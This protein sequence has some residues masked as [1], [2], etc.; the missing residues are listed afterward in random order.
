MKTKIIITLTLLFIS[1]HISHAQHFASNLPD[2]IAKKTCGVGEWIM[3][4]YTGELN[5]D[6]QGYTAE[7]QY[8]PEA[9]ASWQASG[10]TITK[11]VDIM[12]PNRNVSCKYLATST[13]PTGYYRYKIT[14]TPTGAE[15]FSNE[16]L[17]YKETRLEIVTQPIGGEY[18]SITGFTVKVNAFGNNI[19]SDLYFR[20]R[21]YRIVNGITQDVYMNWISVNL[22]Q[23]YP[24]T[25]LSGDPNTSCAGKY[26]AKV[27]FDGAGYEDVFVY[28]DT[29]EVTPKPLTVT[30][31]TIAGKVYNG[32]TTAGL[33]NRGILD[34][35]INGDEVSIVSANV[36]ANFDTKNVVPGYSKPVTI[37]ALPLTG[38]NA[39]MYTITPPTGLTANITPKTLTVTDLTIAGKVYDGNTTATVSNLGTLQG[40]EGSDVVSINQTGVVA[41]FNDKNVGTSKPVTI[42]ALPLIG[43]DAGN[44]LI[45]IPAGLTAGIV[46]FA[47]TVTA[48]PKS[49]TYGEADPALTCSVN[50]ALVQGD[51]FSGTLARV[52]GEAGGQY[53][54]LQNT[55]ALSSN[56][57]LNYVK[58]YLNIYYVPTKII[59]Q[60]QDASI[61]KG[62]SHK[63]SVEADGM[64][65]TYQWYKGRSVIP[66]ANSNTLQISNATSA[67]YELYF[68]EVSG[69]DKQTL[70]SETARLWVAEPLPASLSFKTNLT[71]AVTGQSYQIGLN[72]YPDVTK[73]TWSYSKAGATFEKT[74]TTANSTTVRFSTEA[75]GAGVLSVELAHVCGTRSAS[76]D[77][78]VQYPT[79]IDELKLENL[80]I[81]P[82]PFRNEVHI[83]GA[84]GCNL[85][86]MNTS[87]AVVLSGK[88][89]NSDEIIQTGYLPEGVYLFRLEKDGKVMIVKG[90]KK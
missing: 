31:L 89:I 16:C 39:N 1:C 66:G 75:V 61:C 43:A 83:Q 25:M 34:G 81:F 79:G 78:T 47:V 85:K 10:I 52:P 70:I 59:V 30:G 88:R 15:I 48:D 80:K 5:S 71:P 14:Y 12:G 76:Q 37:S 72:G 18:G 7:L 11:I 9:G 86:V 60:P 27:F 32:N 8:K 49:K 28:T 36:V 19:C 3:V 90:M 13:T 22:D 56:Y 23:N 6:S 69:A 35:I 26:F 51:A 4:V 20:I 65:L 77:V 2:S 44:Y 68:V 64:N 54:I 33:G 50:P 74:E 58:S 41:N 21:W 63:F 82:N 73:Y 45:T 42:S 17:Y 38:A 24:L 46:P 87:G 57:T 40:I 53:E 55:L 62:D 84:E 67:D 29:V